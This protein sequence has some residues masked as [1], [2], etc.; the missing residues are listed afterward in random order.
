[1]KATV[2]EKYKNLT[3]DQLLDKVDDLGSNYEIFSYSCSQCTVAAL[4]EVLEMNDAVVKAA[5]SLCGGTAFQLLGT[6][7]GLAGGIMVLDYFLGR[8]V[9]NLSS[10]QVLQE[11][12]DPLFKAQAIARKLHDKYVKEYG[13]I[14]C[15]GIMSQK[16]GRL[17]FFEDPDEF[18]KFEEAGAH[19]DPE[20][21]AGIVGKAARWVMEILIDEKVLDV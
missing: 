10:E 12:I 3:K 5:T 8:P 16:F 19:T 11:N 2:R 1:M 9:E 21:C 18:T 15:A 4:N 7:G 14:T 20:K 17:Y 13:T 6:C